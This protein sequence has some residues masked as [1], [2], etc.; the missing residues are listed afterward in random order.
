MSPPSVWGP[1]VWALFHTLAEKIKED[2][3]KNIHQELFHYIKRIC[4]YLP[5]PECS[6]HAIMF[7]S[8]VKPQQISNKNDFKN[9]LYY[10]HNQVN[11]RKQKPKFPYSN[12]TKYTNKNIFEVYNH[13]VYVYNTKGNMKMLTESFQRQFVLNDFKKWLFLHK[14]SFM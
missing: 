7:L 11:F 9:M 2:D 3:F 14:K 8:K 13:F 12:I 4:M 10:F 1:P 5:C 6:N